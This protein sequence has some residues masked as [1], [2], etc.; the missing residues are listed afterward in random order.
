MVHG[1]FPELEGMVD[2]VTGFP[3]LDELK[4]VPLYDGDVRCR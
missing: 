1:D 2:P 3:S 4:R